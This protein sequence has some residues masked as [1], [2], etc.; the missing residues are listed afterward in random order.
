[1]GFATDAG[2]NDNVNIVVIYISY[3][4]QIASNGCSD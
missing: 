1:M 3:N 4:G 2:D